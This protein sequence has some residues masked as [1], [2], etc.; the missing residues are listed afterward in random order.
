MLTNK[1]IYYCDAADGPIK[2]YGQPYHNTMPYDNDNVATTCVPPTINILM[3][4]VCIIINIIHPSELVI[5]VFLDDIFGILF[6]RV[7]AEKLLKTE[8]VQSDHFRRFSKF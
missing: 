5:K 4:I 7:T 2:R 1:K 3:D 8:L 6:P